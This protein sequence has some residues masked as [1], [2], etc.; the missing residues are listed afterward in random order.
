[1]ELKR[2]L[3]EKE[4]KERVEDKKDKTERER[5]VCVCVCE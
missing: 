1:M 5:C 2:G 3:R 4:G